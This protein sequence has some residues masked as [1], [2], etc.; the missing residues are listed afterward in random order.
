MSPTSYRLLY[1]AVLDCTCRDFFWNV[2]IM[3]GFFIRARGGVSAEEGQDA[4][5]VV[6]RE[7]LLL[8]C[9]EVFKLDGAGLHL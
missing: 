1:P 9:G 5:D 2:Q 7:G 4:V 6:L 3:S 8:A